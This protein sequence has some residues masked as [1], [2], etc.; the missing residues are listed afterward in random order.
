MHLTFLFHLYAVVITIILFWPQNSLRQPLAFPFHFPSVLSSVWGLRPL[1]E[2]NKSHRPHFPSFKYMCYINKQMFHIFC[3]LMF[4]SLTHTEETHHRTGSTNNNY[5]HFNRTG[6]RE[7]FQLGEGCQF[8]ATSIC[9]ALIR[10]SS[11]PK[12]KKKKRVSFPVQLKTDT[13]E[14][15]GCKL[16]LNY[17]WSTR[18]ERL[19]SKQDNTNSDMK[20]VCILDDSTPGCCF[21]QMQEI[22]QELCV[23]EW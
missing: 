11:Y 12:K 2:A 3:V 1:W 13:Q 21:H 4:T 20:D 14:G 22:F 19:V 9:W 10:G 7:N 6:Q 8:N 15:T 23:S 18:K 16:S 5:S 17:L